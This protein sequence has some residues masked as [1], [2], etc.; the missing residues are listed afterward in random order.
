MKTGAMVKLTPEQQRGFIEKA[1]KSFK[2]C[3]GAWGGQGATNV[4]LA[5]AKAG[6]LRSALNTA[7]KNVGSKKKKMPNVQ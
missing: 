3:S 5:T 2:A 1:P 4:Y 6:I 7:A